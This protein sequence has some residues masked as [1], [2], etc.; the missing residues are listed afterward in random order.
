MTSSGLEKRGIFNK[1]I[2]LMSLFKENG[3]VDESKEI[4]LQR[5]AIA[6]SDEEGTGGLIYFNGKKFI[7][8][9]KGD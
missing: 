7:Q 2:A 3:D 4:K 9:H 1:R 8:I 6:I 5:P